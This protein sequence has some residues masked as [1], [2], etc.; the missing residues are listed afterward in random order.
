MAN[1]RAEKALPAKKNVRDETISY[2]RRRGYIPEFRLYHKNPST[3][4]I[5]R[6]HIVFKPLFSM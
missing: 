2:Q 3:M 6:E 4:F 5:H 1:H